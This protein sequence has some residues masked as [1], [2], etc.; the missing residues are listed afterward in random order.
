MHGLIFP[1]WSLCSPHVYGL[2]TVSFLHFP[3]SIAT[4]CHHLQNLVYAAP[5]AWEMFSFSFSFFLLLPFFPPR[6]FTDLLCHIINVSWRPSWSNKSNV[7]SSYV[8]LSPH[9]S[10]FPCY[11]VNSM[12]DRGIFCNKLIF[13]VDTVPS[14]TILKVL[15]EKDLVFVCLF[16]F[17]CQLSTCYCKQVTN[18]L[19]L[20]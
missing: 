20:T 17:S 3:K 2:I 6:P 10:Y 15:W 16:V 9:F 11:I 12:C 19:R 1:T 7:D 4:S 18:T 13:S 14:S 8:P 5:S